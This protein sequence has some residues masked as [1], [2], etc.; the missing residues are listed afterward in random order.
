ML[1]RG[2]AGLLIGTTYG[3]LVYGVLFL[4]VRPDLMKADSGLMLIS[5]AAI[6]WIGIMISAIITGVCGAFVGL[7]VGLAGLR[8]HNAA[9]VGFVTGLLVLAVLV[10]IS[11]PVHGPNSLRDWI[12]I[13]VSVMIMPFGLGLLGS[14]VAIVAARLRQFCLD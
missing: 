13:L 2:L 5:P 7:I 9:V 11:S 1:I 14:V 12:E 4:L 6:A 8:L 3:F 10:I